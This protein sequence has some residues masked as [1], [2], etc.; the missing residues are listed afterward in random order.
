MSRWP[1]TPPHTVAIMLAF[2]GAAV[3]SRSLFE[4]T[5]TRLQICVFIGIALAFEALGRRVM[6]QRASAVGFAINCLAIFV[7]MITVKTILDG[8]PHT[9]HWIRLAK[10]LLGL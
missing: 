10:H 8:P 9:A 7:G 1:K 5:K 2:G 3:I 4:M 6:G